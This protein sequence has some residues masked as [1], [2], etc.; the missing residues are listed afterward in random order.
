MASGHKSII[1]PQAGRAEAGDGV[2]EMVDV[3]DLGQIVGPS[4]C[5]SAIAVVPGNLIPHR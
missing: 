1:D 2:A 5:G 3:D 4:L